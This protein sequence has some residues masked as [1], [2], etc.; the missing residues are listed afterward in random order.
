MALNIYIKIMFVDFE[1][2]FRNIT[3]LQAFITFIW[4]R[5]YKYITIELM[6]ML[7]FGQYVETT[8]F[9]ER[10]VRSICIITN[11]LGKKNCCNI[12]QSKK[13]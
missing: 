8:L 7:H 4:S 10:S 5:V 2:Y 13:P 11:K 1:N 12:K 6:S 9:C 3:I